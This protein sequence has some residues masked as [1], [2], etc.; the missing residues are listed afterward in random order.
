M[1]VAKSSYLLLTV[2]L[3][4]ILTFSCGLRIPQKAPE[5]ISV[6]YEKHFEFPITTYDLKVK[7]LTSQFEDA[8]PSFVTLHNEDPIT[9]SLATKTEYSPATL[10]K[11]IESKI[12]QELQNL[13]SNFNININA[14]Q[15]VSQLSGN[16]SLPTFG[17]KEYS[18][19]SG[20]ANITIDDLKLVKNQ[21]VPVVA[22]S[23]S[24]TLPSS[25][26]DSLYFSEANFFT[27]EVYVNI[28]GT[29]VS[30]ISLIVDGRSIS[31]TNG[32]SVSVT[33]LLVKKSSNIQVRFNSSTSGT[34]EITLEFREPI[35]NYFKNLDTTKLSAQKVEIAIDQP[36]FTSTENWEIK[37]SGTILEKILADISG[38][39]AQDFTLYSGST[40]V[41]SGNGSGDSVIIN[42][43]KT[44][45]FK[46]SDGLTIR[47]K[48]TLTG[49]I[50]ADFRI[51]TPK[52]K[53]TP[54]VTVSSIKGYPLS[55]SIPLPPNVSELRFSQGTIFIK[56]DGLT[57]S[58]ASGTFGSNQIS[59]SAGELSL[60][61][62]NISLPTTISA[63]IDAD[64]TSP[65]IS[66][67]S[68]F[69]EDA[70]IAKA[71][72]M[73]TTVQPIVVHQPVPDFVKD[74]ADSATINL[75]LDLNYNVSS[76]TSPIT[77]EINSNFLTEGVGTY[78][79]TNAGRI[80]LKSGNKRIAF[81]YT[82]PDYINEFYIQITPILSV[83]I[84]VENVL[85]RD[86]INLSITPDLKAFEVS[87]VALKGTVF[88]Q[89]FGTLYDF[90]NLFPEDFAF[91]ND[92]DFTIDA[93]VAFDVKNSNLS[94][95]ATLTISGNKIH[96]TKGEPVNI[97]NIIKELIKNK[98]KLTLAI[99]MNTGQGTLS[100]DSKIL[101]TLDANLPLQFRTITDVKVKEGTVDLSALR[102][103]K[104]FVKIVRLKFSIFKNTTGLQARFNLGKDSSG[105][106]IVSV[107]INTGDNKDT[108]VELPKETLA[109]LAN[110][111]I[112]WEI[113]VPGD[114]S[115]M[116]NYNGALNV[117]PYLAVEL[118]VATN[119]SLK[120]N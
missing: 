113:I 70:K 87:Q 104:D 88:S 84:I 80:V 1:K 69:S 35:L 114:K 25:L 98:Q 37:L 61:L 64:V 58:S 93:Y 99:E 45:F 46:L 28:T 55:I 42:I 22:G 65:S 110:D 27:T 4:L 32:S 83:P 18:L 79:L 53:I 81:N 91:L 90:E 119:I 5:K 34:V 92:F 96:L 3:A 40:I 105:K 49:T 109:L 56:F 103:I 47:G 44:K 108:I 11:G 7:D 106:P 52:V 39:I 101:F 85:L 31:L 29:S 107:D 14:S 23:N 94:P 111:E 75:E 6:K 112:P 76:I 17:S 115:I 24:F 38:T 48:V 62:Y 36:I 72:L 95:E 13:S 63:V 68:S 41:G 26:L 78:T 30:N 15:F 102:S 12:T 21:S 59:L 60:P 19:P 97:G 100:N 66:Y 117:A 77:I 10:L 16:L 8:L 51:Q 118:D 86:G 82:D 57:L 20:S 50:T 74:L 33:N 2:L 116:L 89:D 9:L 67:S 71:M 54:S 120:S 73:N 43:D